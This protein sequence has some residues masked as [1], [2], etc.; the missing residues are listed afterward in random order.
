[1]LVLCWA[2]VGQLF[3]ELN[4][5][6]RLSVAAA[7]DTVKRITLLAALCT[8]SKHKYNSE[9]IIDEQTGCTA[10]TRCRPQGG[11]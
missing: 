7:K 10:Q 9:S 3:K 2:T 8:T 6:L 5:T 1:M 4:V 11:A